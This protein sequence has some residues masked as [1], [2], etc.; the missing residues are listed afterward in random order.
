MQTSKPISTISYNTIEF[1]TSVLDYL[2]RTH[3]IDYYMFIPHIG[4]DDGFGENEKDHIHLFIIPNHRINTANL[5]SYFIEPVPNS[6]P[7][8]CI[9]WNTSNPDDWILYV[10]HDPEY[11]L[12]KFEHRE[13]QYHFGNIK[14]SCKET[15]RRMFRHAYQSSGY[16]RMRNLY[17]YAASNGLLT[18]LMRIGAIPINQIASYEQYFAIARKNDVRMLEQDQDV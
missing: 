12:T 7:L 18:D 6:L 16:A 15:L 1:L 8:K 10:L 11:L 13:L 17:Q 2:I 14:S 5:D 4:E 9:N 3:V